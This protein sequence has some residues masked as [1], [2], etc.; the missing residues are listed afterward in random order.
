MLPLSGAS[1][2][3]G[4]L[5]MERVSAYARARHLSSGATDGELDRVVEEVHGTHWVP[6]TDFVIVG[7]GGETEPKSP[8]A[9]RRKLDRALAE[10]ERMR[11]RAKRAER[12]LRWFTPGLTRRYCGD[13]LAEPVST[14][15]SETGQAGAKAPFTYDTQQMMCLG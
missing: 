12:K 4:V 5:R 3:D 15:A 2:D 11:A 10:V 7:E 8:E 6:G 9:L 14:A 13:R 1:R